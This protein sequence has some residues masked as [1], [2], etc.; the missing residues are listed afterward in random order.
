LTAALLD[1]KTQP[2]A[3]DDDDAVRYASWSA[4][5]EAF[6]LDVLPGV[7]VVAAMALLADSAP[8]GGC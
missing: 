2:E 4:R 3:A 8:P 1:E 7:A 6:A 5:S